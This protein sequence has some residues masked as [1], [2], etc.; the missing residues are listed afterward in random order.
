M[1]KSIKDDD[2]NVE[3]RSSRVWKPRR[4][5]PQFSSVTSDCGMRDTM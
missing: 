4:A 1:R 5:S 3:Q 2:S